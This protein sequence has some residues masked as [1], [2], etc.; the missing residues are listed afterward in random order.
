MLHWP[1]LRE[2]PYLLY[3]AK[4]NLASMIADARQVF[5]T[6]LDSQTHTLDVGDL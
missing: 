4:A 6:L 1:I 5:F 3:R 2:T